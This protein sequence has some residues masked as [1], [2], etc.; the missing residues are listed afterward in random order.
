MATLE[1]GINHV[2]QEA[3]M[4]RLSAEESELQLQLQATNVVEV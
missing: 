1:E 3:E 2:E 4:A